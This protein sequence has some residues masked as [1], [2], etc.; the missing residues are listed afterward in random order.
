MFSFTIYDYY[1][2]DDSTNPFYDTT[3]FTANYRILKLQENPP[4]PHENALKQR[5][6]PTLP[7]TPRYET[8]HL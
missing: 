6:F 1:K 4:A 5:E 7:V 2:T 3:I 8:V